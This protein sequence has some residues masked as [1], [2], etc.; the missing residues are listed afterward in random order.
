M[1]ITG[2]KIKEYEELIENGNTA[3]HLG[4]R[5]TYTSDQTVAYYYDKNHNI[6]TATSIKGNGKSHELISSSDKLATGQEIYNAI[7]KFQTEMEGGVYLA[8]DKRV[9]ADYANA[10]WKDEIDARF[11]YLLKNSNHKP[12]LSDVITFVIHKHG[13]R[14]WFPKLEKWG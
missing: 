12:H 13:Y 10:N 5:R 6:L 1:T 4:T 11:E 2:M 9:T 3:V 7:E 14:R 8:E